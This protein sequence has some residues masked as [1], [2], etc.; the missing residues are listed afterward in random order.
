MNNNLRQNL[1]RC[2]IAVEL[3]QSIKEELSSY[4]LRLKQINRN[5]KWVNPHSIHVTLKFFGEIEPYEVEKVGGEL[6][7]CKGIVNPFALKITGSG[8][9]PNERRPR[10]FWLGLQ[11]DERRSLFRLHEWIDEQ[12]EPLGFE[13]EKRRFSPHLT[14]GRVKHPDDFSNVFEYLKEHPFEPATLTVEEIVF[15]RSEL[16]PTGAEYTPIQKFSL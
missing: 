7:N 11:Q 1:I 10:V 16:K 6:Q 12:L 9:F 5:I 13:K 8:A 15:M 3:P 4:I 14:L 2:F